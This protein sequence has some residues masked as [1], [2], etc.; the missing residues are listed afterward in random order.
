MHRL[1]DIKYHLWKD[2]GIGSPG[3]D[4]EYDELVAFGF[5]VAEFLMAFQRRIGE[6]PMIAHFHEWQGSAAIPIVK[7]RG[8]KFATVFT[9][10]ATM[11]GRNLSAAN[12]ELYENMHHIDGG[13]VARDHLFEHRHALEGAVT[14]AADVFT[15]V[16]EI[17]A[18]ES[19]HFLGRRP[20]A[21]VPNGLNIE[22][23]A[24]PHEF[25]VL[26]KENKERI[27]EFVMGHF[28]P[29]YH[30]DLDKTLYVFTSGRYEYRNK[31]LDVFIEALHEL[32]HRMRAERSANPRSWLSSSRAHPI[33]R[34]TSNRSIARR[35]STSCARP[36]SV[37]AEEMG[38][39]LIH[40]IVH[41][42]DADD[43]GSARRVRRQ[44]GIKRMMYALRHGTLP[45]IITHDLKDDEKDHGAAASARTAGYGTAKKIA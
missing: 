35:C 8:A 43:G 26:H 6:R 22:R 9:T 41:R 25:Q 12:Y 11:V 1:A 13:A 14:H 18:V 28:F 2:N 15:T 34:S 30:F 7:H 37:V 31:G 20:D 42:P 40:T 36:V 21:L 44:S 3:G 24:A 39:R 16:S 45:S 38:R 19:E 32:N 33:T 27:H 5:A 17:T 4:R 23:F 10:H 29:S